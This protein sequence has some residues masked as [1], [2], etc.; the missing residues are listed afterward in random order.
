M[1]KSFHSLSLVGVESSV[2]YEEIPDD[3]HEILVKKCNKL[4]RQLKSEKITSPEKSR[5]LDWLIDEIQKGV[6]RNISFDKELSYQGFYVNIC[7]EK[8]AKFFQIV[9]RLP[10]GTMSVRAYQEEV[11]E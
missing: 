9:K 1:L 11:E 6:E 8:D 5:Q 10:D 3:L 7:Y 4:I 2:M